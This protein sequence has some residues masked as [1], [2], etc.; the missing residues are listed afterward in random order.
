MSLL[1]TAYEIYFKKAKV[2]I[3]FQIDFKNTKQINE[4]SKL[5]EV[6]EASFIQKLKMDKIKPAN[7]CQFCYQELDQMSMDV[8]IASFHQNVNKCEI[9]EKF[10]KTQTTLKNHF[11]S[12]HDNKDRIISCNICTKTF[13]IKKKLTNHMKTVHGGH[14]NHKCTSCG[15]SFSES[16]TLN[17][18][19][20]TVHE[21]HK[22]YK[23]V[24]CG[25]VI[26]QA[27]S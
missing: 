9:C 8:H 22:D 11:S 12:V 1:F 13:Q 5:G 25:V 26:S 7:K 14:K 23:C 17:R 24:S 3:W 2:P 4:N 27:S 16:G 19:M 18:H 15:K 6:D 10:F 21:G 20:H